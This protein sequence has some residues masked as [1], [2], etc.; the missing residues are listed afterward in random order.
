MR[1]QQSIPSVTSNWSFADALLVMAE[2]EE[3]RRSLKAFVKAVWPL[4]E[5][6]PF[7]DGWVVDALCEHFE[8]VTLGQIRFLLINIP[9]RHTKSTIGSVIWPT[10]DWL[11]K[12]EDRFLCASYSLDLA[13]RDNL[14][15][16]NL[17]ESPWFQVLYGTAFSLMAVDMQFGRE[18]EFA[19]SEDQNAKR[20][21]MNDK[22][23]YQLAVSVGSTT[24][25]QGGS[26][27]LIDDP[28]SAMEAHSEA[29]RRTAA[30][31][32]K[33]TWS[34]RM[35]DASKDAMVVIGQRI[36]E[37]DISGLIL[38]E[39]TDWVHLDLPAEFEPSRKCYT[40]I[41][42]SDPRTVEGELLWPERF[43]AETIQRYKRDLGS[44]GYAAQYQQRPVPSDG[45]IFK[46]QWIRY[47]SET[48]NAYILH[49]ESGNTSVL[50]SACW[51]F[52][53]VD[54]AVSLKQT[55]D[56]TV[57][58]TY[59]VTPQ[60]DLLLIDQ[61]R[62]RMDNP[63]QQKV[64]REVY[65]RLHPEFLKV[66]SAGYQLAVVQQLRNEP[67]NQ[68]DFLIQGDVNPQALERTFW[69][70]P[71]VDAYLLQEMGNEYKTI[72]GC[73]VARVLGDVGFFK[74]AVEKQGYCKIV[75]QPGQ[76][77][78]RFSIP[79]KEYRPVK[80]KVSRASVAAIQME[81]EKVFFKGNALYLNELLSE[82]LMFPMGAH[83][84]QVDPIGMACD[85]VVSGYGRGIPVV[86]SSSTALT[87]PQRVTSEDESE[88]TRLAQQQ[89]RVANIMNSLRRLG[90]TPL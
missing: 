59:D 35:N 19:L 63:K 49:K 79:V 44:I 32:F 34:N 60:N 64:L 13:I 50:K 27:L 9:P 81:A 90:G 71:G 82:L 89:D 69:D 5:P 45:G 18:H 54:L 48:E 51:R 73:Y 86:V 56:Y 61:I 24:T 6:S 75:G 78:H 11:H 85:E 80:D 31:W 22:L 25:G 62:D 53:T 10:W 58:Q 7:V 1:K 55:A 66:E 23:G 28:H 57:I 67:T 38:S 3:Y 47:F 84:D 12:P 88:N 87:A 40:S 21:F 37:K 4:V 14:K 33:E 68:T 43:N 39:R 76:I 2:A 46:K 72:N 20:F 26:K 41:G 74:Y 52:T 65:S 30:S 16:R 83:D 15:K 42:W 8:A 70:L 77:P 29:D 36:H 17:I